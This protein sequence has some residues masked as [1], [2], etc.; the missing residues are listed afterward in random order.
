MTGESYAG[1]YI[2]AFSWKIV[3]SNNTFNL[4]ASLI[5][6]PYTAALTQKTSM[7]IVPEALN[8]LDDSNMPQIA[9]LR[10]NCQESLAADI[11][12]S[13]DICSA[14]MAY[15]EAVSGGVYAYDQRIFSVD[16]DPVENPVINYFSN[17]DA[18]TLNQIYASIHVSDSTKIPVFQM[19]N[20]AVSEAL[21]ADH[22]I[23]Y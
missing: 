20:G 18:A 9:A 8:I 12:K 11:M 22:M 19:S 16:W 10:K 23:D 2:P 15:I 5:G 17:Q 13:Y 7:Y 6:D 14:I 1:H 3:E 4:K 21:M